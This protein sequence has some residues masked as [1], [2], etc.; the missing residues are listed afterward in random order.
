M[1]YRMMP[2]RLIL[3]VFLFSYA[4]QVMAHDFW[5]EPSNFNPGIGD[6]VDIHLRVGMDFDGEIVPRM[7]N[8]FDRFEYFIGSNNEALPIKGKEWNDPAG[9]I[10]FEQNGLYLLGF[11]SQ[12]QAIVIDPATFTFY[13]KEEGLDDILRLR[14]SRGESE[15]KGNEIFLRCCKALIPC[16][17]NAPTGFE[18]QLGFKLELIPQKNPLV[19]HENEELPLQLLFM[20]E[21]VKN[22]LVAALEKKTPKERITARTDENGMVSLRIPQQGHWLIKAVHMTEVNDENVYADW[23]SFWASLVFDNQKND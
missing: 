6:N 2:F 5:I 19:L 8:W 21:P 20:G 13:L 4:L 11:Q 23:Q 9:S 22:G 12:H 1:P 3:M 10:S 7:S 14:E 17:D 18:R 16:G 15:K